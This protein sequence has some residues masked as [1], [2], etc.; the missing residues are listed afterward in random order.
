MN[1]LTVFE[2]LLSLSSPVPHHWT[3][4][5][6]LS[7]QHIWSIRSRLAT[8]A[9]STYAEDLSA[10]V[11]LSTCM[12]ATI[13]TSCATSVVAFVGITRVSA[14]RLFLGSLL[15]SRRRRCRRWR[16]LRFWLVSVA[17]LRN[18]LGIL[19]LISLKND[20]SYFDQVMHNAKAARDERSGRRSMDREV[21]RLQRWHSRLE[22]D[23][24]HFRG[25]DL[26]FH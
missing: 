17:Q 16:A 8:N 22:I 24:R 26:I 4:H 19:L 1:R 14:R 11:R 6:P 21:S 2:R 20:K 12:A 23:K 9:A 10:L 18:A 5:S 3:S 13:H 15:W 25:C 7:R